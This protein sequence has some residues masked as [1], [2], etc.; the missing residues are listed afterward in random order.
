MKNDLKKYVFEI[1]VIFIGI[2][3]SFLF[4]GW[5]KDREEI[6]EVKS[7]LIALKNDLGRTKKYIEVIDSG[8]MET[9]YT[10]SNFRN[11]EDIDE[12]DFVWLIW[13]IS[14]TTSDGPLR[15]L[16]PYLNQI[17]G[18]NSHSIFQE[19]DRI[20]TLIANIQALIQQEN[21]LS[22]VVSDYTAQKIWPKLNKGDLL[23]TIIKG[24]PGGRW[25]SDTT[26]VYSEKKYSIEMFANLK[27][28]L[29]LVELKL[30]RIVQ[31]HEA[32]KRQI[33]R[34]KEELDKIERL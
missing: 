11:S 3:T 15:G 30:M 33:G 28:D 13:Q 29:A 9:I 12:E 24:D 32:L 22:K 1:A 14:E 8:Y 5:R 23:N 18:T 20:N 25:G 6:R 19:S 16:T 34:L 26:L 27:A 21:E 31:A 17:S 10:I 7:Q 2:T 4:D